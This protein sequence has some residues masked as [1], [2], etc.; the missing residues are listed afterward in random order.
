M[1]FKR[2]LTSFKSAWGNDLNRLNKIGAWGIA[3]GLFISWQYFSDRPKVEIIQP[4]EIE[5]WNKKVLDKSSN[6]KDLK[7]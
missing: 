5:N 6:K 1:Q 7:S 2:I 4:N 3:I